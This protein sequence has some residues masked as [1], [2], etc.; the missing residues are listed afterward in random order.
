MTART[1][2]QSMA[3]ALLYVSANR[4]DTFDQAGYEST[5]IV[6]TLVGQI[7]NF[8]NH[9]MTAQILTF[10][11]VEDAVIQKLKGSKDYGT[12]SMMLANIPSDAGQVI[13]AAAGESQNRYSA[14]ID[15]PLGDGEAT[16]EKHYI[17]AL[18]A[19]REHQDGDANAIRK[20]AV[21][22]AICKKPIEVAAT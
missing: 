18:V 11:A 7:E 14:R 13:L 1:N 19:T 20:L 5:D 9:G 6:W 4:P 10:T 12:M 16:K 21:A 22:L 15:Y 2:V 17:D 8:G 3:G